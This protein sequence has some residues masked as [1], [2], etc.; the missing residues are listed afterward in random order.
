MCESR[1]QQRKYVFLKH[2]EKLTRLIKYTECSGKSS[3]I[4]N[5]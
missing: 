5:I 3:K 1:N 2:V 4:I